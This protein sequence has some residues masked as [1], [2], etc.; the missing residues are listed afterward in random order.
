M[1]QQHELFDR[2]YEF[3]VWVQEVRDPAEAASEGTRTIRTS[4]WDKLEYEIAPLPDGR[5]ALT[6][7]MDCARGGQGKPWTAY[8]TRELAIAGFLDAATRFL[9]NRSN[10]FQSPAE[11]A[12]ANKLLAKLGKMIDG[13]RF[14]EPEPTEPIRCV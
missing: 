3:D 4:K 14:D 6:W 2:F 10:H 13:D 1:H 5:W 9:T 12:K 7:D 11:I 8:E